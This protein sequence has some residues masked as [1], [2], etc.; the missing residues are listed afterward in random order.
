MQ[1]SLLVLPPLFFLIN[2]L[3]TV[4]IRVAHF[5]WFPAQTKQGTGFTSPRPSSQKLSRWRITTLLY[6][7]L[8]GGFYPT[9]KSLAKIYPPLFTILTI[10]LRDVSCS[11]R[12]RSLHTVRGASLLLPPPGLGHQTAAK[13]QVHGPQSDESI[14]PPHIFILFDQGLDF[15]SLVVE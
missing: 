7:W 5:C 10:E 15:P 13:Q 8:L 1:M 3:N 4:W 9:I 6:I 14:P 2:E 11:T 12:T